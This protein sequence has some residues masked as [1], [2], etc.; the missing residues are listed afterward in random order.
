MSKI[1][2][3]MAKDMWEVGKMVNKMDKDICYLKMAPNLKGNG[4]LVKR[5]N[6]LLKTN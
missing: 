1:K 3:L 6:D 4:V 2:G 5:S